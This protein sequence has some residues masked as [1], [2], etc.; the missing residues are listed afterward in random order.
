[1]L[2]PMSGAAGY[3]ISGGL[4]GGGTATDGEL[5]ISFITDKII[6][7]LATGDL[8]MIAALNGVPR[9][10]AA[11]ILGAIYFIRG[12]PCPIR[13]TRINFNC[14]LRRRLVN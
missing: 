3:I 14:R 13:C 8:N 6:S 4:A 10:A 11:T 1:M 7:N 12:D 9:I 5:P 2:D